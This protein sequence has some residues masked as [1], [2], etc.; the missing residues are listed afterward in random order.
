M[1]I[2]TMTFIK[3]D[4]SFLHISELAYNALMASLFQLKRD[5]FCKSLKLIHPPSRLK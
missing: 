2:C 5:E 4:L 1:R 3:P